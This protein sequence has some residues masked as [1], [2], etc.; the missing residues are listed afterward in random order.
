MSLSG[1]NCILFKIVL[2]AH[3]VHRKF[4][5]NDVASDVVS[6]NWGKFVHNDVVSDV[7]GFNWGGWCKCKGSS[8]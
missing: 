4:V 2:G 7:V 3:N 8:N 6:F 5:H 1:V